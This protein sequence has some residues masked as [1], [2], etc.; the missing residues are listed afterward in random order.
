MSQMSNYLENELL[1]HS[2]GTGAFT[3]PTNVYISLYTT[4]PTDADS[5]TEVSGFGYARQLVTFGASAG[6]SASNSTE[7]TFTASGG[8]WGTITHIGIHDAISAGNLLYHGALS[9]S[10]TVDDAE[11]LIFSIGAVTI[12]LA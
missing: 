12:S 11:S 5:G 9:A 6:G 4:D 8:S 2:L 10:R 7:E 1:D 3:A